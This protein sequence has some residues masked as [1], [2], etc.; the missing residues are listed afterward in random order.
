[1]KQKRSICLSL[2]QIKMK[3]CPYCGNNGKFYLKVYSRIYHR[4]SKCDLIYKDFQESYDKSVAVYRD[5]YFS[6]YSSEQLRGNRNKLF[7]SILN[8]IERKRQVGRLLDVGTGCGFFLVA[9][10][11]RGWKPAGIEPSM[12]SVEFGR[13]KSRLDIFHGTLMEYA[14]DAKLDAITFINVLEHSVEPWQEI[15][16][17]G[18]FLK[19]GGLIY[20]RFPNGLVHGKIQL[21]ASR[22]GLS[23]RV[24][25]FLVFHKYSFTPGYIRRLLSD[26]GFSEITF[27]NSQLSEGDPGGLFSNVFVTRAAKR[28]FYLVA[29]AIEIITHKQLLLGP[30]LEVTATKRYAG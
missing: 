30:S 24:G 3:N 16:R 14:G 10:Q 2:N 25:R 23:N 21:L 17:A 13:K 11:K 27:Q 19:P 6:K 26:S 28:S 5:K 20:I 4:C 1:M 18:K 8:R 29:K 12:Q 22:I 9:A 7:E 15:E